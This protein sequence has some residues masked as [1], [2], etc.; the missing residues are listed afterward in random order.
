VHR[1]PMTLA[2]WADSQRARS[3]AARPPNTTRPPALTFGRAARDVGLL[4]RAKV[5]RS[6]DDPCDR[7]TTSIRR[8]QGRIHCCVACGQIQGPRAAM[9]AGAM[10]HTFCDV[11]VVH[12]RFSL[13]LGV[14]TTL[15][16]GALIAC[17]APEAA[18]DSTDEA[19]TVTSCAATDKALFFH[20]L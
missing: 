9:L 7:V 3:E 2:R 8:H 13:P 16:A 5:P 12:P 20:G 4:A 18:S 6:P 1:G 17:S 15:T 14:L 19:L 10:W 11:E